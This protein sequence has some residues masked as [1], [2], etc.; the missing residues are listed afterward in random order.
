MNHSTRYPT[1]TWLLRKVPLGRPHAQWR[2]RKPR[3]LLLESRK[4]SLKR[5]RYSEVLYSVR[6][7]CRVL[8]PF[9][10]LSGYLPNT[11]VGTVRKLRIGR[12]VEYGATWAKEWSQAVTHIIVDGH[13]S[14]PDVE[15]AYGK[16]VLEV[17]MLSGLA[18]GSDAD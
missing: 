11:D 3:N 13:L 9:L 17:E 14:L 18:S 7:S 5:L 2:K 10:T 16:E 4:Y 1:P 12:A 8:F 15:K 6:C